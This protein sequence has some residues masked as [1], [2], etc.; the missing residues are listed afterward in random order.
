MFFGIF[1]GN[2]ITAGLVRDQVRNTQYNPKQAVRDGA[3]S[4]LHLYDSYDFYI[5]YNK[6]PYSWL[7]CPMSHQLPVV[8][9]M[10]YWCKYSNEYHIYRTANPHSSHRSIQPPSLARW[11]TNK[12]RE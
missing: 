5:W 10:Y 11:L 4:N 1:N 2:N 3:H 7:T 6:H 9:H 12:C 8:S